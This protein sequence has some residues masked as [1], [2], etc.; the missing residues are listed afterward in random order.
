MRASAGDAA[1]VAGDRRCEE[2]L[3]SGHARVHPGAIHQHGRLTASK[4]EAMKIGLVS[5]THGDVAAW[6]QALEIFDAC[7]LILHAGDHLYHGAFNPVLPT[8]DPRGLA[9]EMNECPIPILHARG[10]CDS[11]VDQLALNDPIMTPYA[12]CRL[13]GLNILVAH[14]DNLDRME[15]VE[16][17]LAYGVRILLRGHTHIR[18]MWEHGPMLV[19]NP[20]SPSLPKGDGVP[21]V[22]ILQGDGVSLY[23]IRSG[24]LLATRVLPQDRP[25]GGNPAVATGTDGEAGTSQARKR[26]N[27]MQG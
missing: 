23:D 1:V 15:L 2:G 4:G 11:E 7:E 13:E 12:F 17:A 20:G 8:Y 26:E 24:D 18:G 25:G 22:G 27:P 14:G 21:S 16:M 9:R 10:N 3:K 6:R 19:C 5:D